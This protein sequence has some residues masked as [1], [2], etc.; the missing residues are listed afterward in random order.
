MW[1][2]LFGLAL[3]S[4]ACTIVTK[5]AD[6]DSDS[7][8]KSHDDQDAS[9]GH[10]TTKP[11]EE[12]DS[13]SPS[14]TSTEEPTSEETTA[15]DEDSGTAAT[16]S[17]GG[18]ETTG[19]NDGGSEEPSTGDGGTGATTGPTSE[20]DAGDSTGP[21][22]PSAMI[23]SF[24]CGSPDTTGA[25]TISGYIDG[26]QNWSGVVIVDGE[27]HTEAGKITI[28]AGT[29]FVMGVDSS[30]EFGWNGNAGTV[31][32]SGTEDAPI[33]FCGE[34]DEAGFWK[35]VSFASN[36]TSNSKFENVLIKNAGGDAGD[37]ASAL[38][39]NADVLINNVVVEGSGNIGVSALDFDDAS[40]G[41]FVTGSASYPVALNAAPAVTHLPTGSGLTGNAKDFAVV[42]LDYIEDDTTF[43][44]LDVPYLIASSISAEAIALTFE[45]G[46]DAVFASDQFLDVGWNGNDATLQIEGTKANPVVFRGQDE[47]PGFWAGVTVESNVRSASKI[48][49]L[50]LRNGGGSDSAALRVR[51]P[52]T[53]SHVTLDGNEMGA[54][55][56]A[57]GLAEGSTDWKITGGSDVPLTIAPEAW[58]SLPTASSFTGNDRD[59]IVVLGGYPVLEGTILNPGVPY[60]LK[61][62]I[63]F[64]DGTN[65]TIEAGTEFQMGSDGQLTIGWNGGAA[66]F[67]AN[68]TEDAPIRF[69]GAQD[70]AGYWGGVYVDNNVDSASNMDWV[71]IHNAGVEGSAALHLNS[72]ISV[73]NCT[74]ADSEGWGIIKSADDDT[75]YEANNTFDNVAQ[76][77]VTQ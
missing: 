56:E 11:S 18:V 48:E 69:V 1:A 76:G 41:L 13:G 7:G 53:I 30:I 36:I 34:T 31:I 28:A 55:I 60:S 19:D 45:A 8:S 14:P 25:T 29:Q 74:F 61:D 57:V 6:D 63:N 68:G 66:E 40:S 35:S 64:S 42:N 26:D 65:L 71:E 4:Q 54:N 5:N 73:Q 2:S 46:V 77:N 23:P 38:Y 75:D 44:D 9:T 51:S 15:T 20:T 59:M 33:T 17:D 3:A 16:E 72:P 37:S 49:Y 32:A 10:T 39:L 50:E 24:G 22:G 70:R 21:T 67:H 62:S 58:V 12:V 43:H 47:R 52:I 27:V